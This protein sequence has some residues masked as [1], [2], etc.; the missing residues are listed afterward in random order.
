MKKT[1]FGFKRQGNNFPQIA[2]AGFFMRGALMAAVAFGLFFASSSAQAAMVING[3]NFTT[4]YDGNA[5]PQNSTPAWSASGTNA[6]VNAGVLTINTTAAQSTYYTTG[7]ATGWSPT[8]DGST[9]EF[10]LQVGSV[11]SG[12]TYTTSMGLYNGVKAYSLSF[13]DTG[14][15]VSNSFG[16]FALDTTSDFVTY[17]FVLSA[18]ALASQTASLYV[19]NSSTALFS[20]YAGGGDSKNNFIRF[21]DASGSAGGIAKYDYVAFTNAGAYAP[22]PEPATVG[23]ALLGLG[24]FAARRRHQ[25]VA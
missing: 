18:N 25:S 20:G 23:L 13:T 1:S 8:T 17:R 14:I 2:V 7:G 9:V 10:G 24:I 11:A 6:S 3:V 5:L 15:V 16:T 12:A 19:N 4:V 22:V 21:G